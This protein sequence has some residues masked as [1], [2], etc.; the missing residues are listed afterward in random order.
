MT[1]LRLFFF[2]APRI[3]RDGSPIDLE[4]RKALALAAYLA[5]SERPPTRD[6]LTAILW[7]DLDQERARAALR[8]T[9][10]ALTALTPDT[11]IDADR[12]TVALVPTAV[13]IDTTEFLARISAVRLHAHAPDTLCDE[14]A[15]H[16]EQAVALYHGDFLE[17]FNLADSADFDDWQMFQREWLR[18]E[19][20]GA[21]RRLAIY[22]GD[23]R[24]LRPR[25]H[26]RPPLAVAR[27]T[28]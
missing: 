4:R 5:L 22:Y 2:G 19:C 28:A 25:H 20:G 8:S 11:W 7:P 12:A 3:E 16:L 6:T 23:A 15:A 17:G 26:A 18:R 1:D 14:C 9:L 27:S 13:W 21:L 24:R 10:P